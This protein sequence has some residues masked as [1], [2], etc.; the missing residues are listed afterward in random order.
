MI[1]TTRFSKSITKNEYIEMEKKFIFR[2][3]Q[4]KINYWNPL[5][6]DTIKKL[7]KGLNK[8]QNPS[9]VWFYHQLIE[10]GFRGFLTNWPIANRFFT[11]FYFPRAHLAVEIDGPEHDPVMDSRRDRIFALVGVKTFRVKHNDLPAAERLL[12]KLEANPMCVQGFKIAHKKISECDMYQFFPPA[13]KIIQP[14]PALLAPRPTRII[15]R[16][17]AESNF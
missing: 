8:A 10:K 13:V 14:T 5:N 2:C 17:K 9:E 3:A 16:K 11:D 1:T 7:R 15:L 4:K 12:R 6:F